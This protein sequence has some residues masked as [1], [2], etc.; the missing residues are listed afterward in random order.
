MY[1]KNPH[2]Q[3]FVRNI[4]VFIFAEYCGQQFGSLAD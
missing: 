1:V 4:S 2:K 3:I